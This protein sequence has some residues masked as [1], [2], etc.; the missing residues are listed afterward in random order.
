MAT[1]TGVTLTA[2]P[3]GEGDD[4]D[5]HYWKYSLLPD[6]ASYATQAIRYN[7]V[8]VEVNGARIGT[9]Y[10][11]AWS[12]DVVLESDDT[13]PY[14]LDE[15]R[16]IIDTCQDPILVLPQNGHA[17]ELVYTSVPASTRLKCGV[18]TATGLSPNITMRNVGEPTE[19]TVNVAV[20]KDGRGVFQSPGAL[21]TKNGG[22]AQ[23]TFEASSVVRLNVTTSG[24][25]PGPNNTRIVKGNPHYPFMNT[26]V[27]G[28][29]AAALQF[30]TGIA[31]SST[32]PSPQPG[33][34]YWASG[35]VANCIIR[36]CR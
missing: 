26:Q 7:T 8:T 27:E 32:S 29:P 33:D 13:L 10:H 28:H 31:L 20:A 35:G 36:A 23:R 30:N 34:G 9:E 17:N 2:T 22:A 18:D 11:A 12:P 1:G 4:T 15:V 16:G 25:V 6:T 21:F 5:S 24:G 19:A 14:T 3:Q